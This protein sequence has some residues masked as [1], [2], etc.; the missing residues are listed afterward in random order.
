MYLIHLCVIFIFLTTSYKMTYDETNI[1]APLFRLL[2]P[3][4]ALSN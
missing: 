4:S 3:D 1:A 2:Q